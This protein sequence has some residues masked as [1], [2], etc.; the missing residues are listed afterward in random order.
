M[1]NI[2]QELDS[3]RLSDFAR[4]AREQIG[5]ADQL[6]ISLKNLVLNPSM[7]P[8]YE[9]TVALG[10]EDG[11]SVLYSREETVDGVLWHRFQCSGRPA[12][13]AW[14]LEELDYHS[15]RS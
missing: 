2:Y 4:A 5:Q 12:A 10:R 13:V 6:T 15:G 3:S 1:E 7:E 8:V 11:L 9:D 14:L